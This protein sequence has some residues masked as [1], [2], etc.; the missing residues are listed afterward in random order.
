[1]LS[2]FGQS[3]S[4]TATIAGSRGIPASGSIVFQ[5]GDTPIGSVA[6]NRTTGKAVLS[7]AALEVG[8]HTVVAYY[9]GDTSF[10]PSASVAVLQRVAKAAT[11]TAL[12][13]SANPASSG[14]SITFTARVTS[15]AGTPSGSVVFLDEQKVLGVVPLTGNQATVTTKNLKK[16]LHAIT[17]IYA[18]N[19]H[20]AISFGLVVQNVK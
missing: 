5:D 7:T 10:N 3:V 1:M 11:Q 19:D 8:K 4:F 20:Y 17:A 14:Q 12:T 18:G 13:S 6:F 9:R 2:R 15:T 16:G